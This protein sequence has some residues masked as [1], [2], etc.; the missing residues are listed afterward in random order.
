MC[1]PCALWRMESALYS[2]RKMLVLFSSGFPLTAE[3]HSE[4]TAT[5]DALQQIQRRRL[6]ARRP[7]TAS[8]SAKRR[9][10][11]EPPAHRN[12]CV[13]QVLIAKVPNRSSRSWSLL[14]TLTHSAPRSGTGGTGGG[15]AGGGGWHGRDWRHGRHRCGRGGT[16]EPV[17]RGTGAG[18]AAAELVAPGQVEPAAERVH[19]RP[20]RRLKQVVTLRLPYQQTTTTIFEPAALHRSAI[21]GIRFTN[22]R[23]SRRSPKHWGFQFQHND[24]F[25][26]PAHRQRAKRFYL[27]GYS[28]RICEGSCHTLKVKL[29]TVAQ[30]CARVEAIATLASRTYP[31]N[32]TA[33]V[34]KRL[35]SVPKTRKRWCSSFFPGS[36]TFTRPE[37]R[38][39]DLAMEDSSG[40]VKFDKDKGKYQLESQ[41]PGHSLIA[42]TAHRRK[43]QRSGET[44]SRKGRM[45][46]FHKNCLP[47]QNQ[48][49]A[50]S[51]HYK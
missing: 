18:G 48:F 28:P 50:R 34:E 14:P 5:I 35:K 12:R 25:A 23:S 3:R 29:I 10:S 2:G 43:V 11:L 31:E 45:K 24:L 21:S 26:A 39:R 32:G 44:R 1:F 4:L 6:F 17:K 37:S 22:Q 16:R 42:K 33:R 19:D 51:R 49:D 13:R 20:R 8:A 9:R 41:R 27:L 7:W 30:T 38:S 46:D 47:Y 36:P 40:N 15:G